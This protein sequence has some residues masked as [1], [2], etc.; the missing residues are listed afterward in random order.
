MPDRQRLE[1]S[2]IPLRM[3][4]SD[5][6]GTVAQSFVESFGQGDMQELPHREAVVRCVQVRVRRLADLRNGSRDD[7]HPHRLLPPSKIDMGTAIRVSAPMRSNS[8]RNSSTLSSRHC[9]RPDR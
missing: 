6:A 7:R 4:A 1:S 9:G 8:V 5:S 3:R 2:H